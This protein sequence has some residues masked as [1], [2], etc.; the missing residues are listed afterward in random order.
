MREYKLRKNV[1]LCLL[2]CLSVSSRFTLSK[3]EHCKMCI[4]HHNL[5]PIHNVK[6]ALKQS[7]YNVMSLQHPMCQRWFDVLC[8]LGQT[9]D[10]APN[11]EKC[12]SL[13]LGYYHIQALQYNTMIFGLYVNRILPYSTWGYRVL[14]CLVLFLSSNITPNGFHGFAKHFL[15]HFTVRTFWWL[16]WYA[17]KVFIN[18]PTKTTIYSIAIAVSLW[19]TIIRISI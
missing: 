2:L 10:R 15:E 16:I 3:S 13:L 11:T 1:Y 19:I 17:D 8:P 5:V 6:S 9:I 14:S 18:F 12:E 4:F 7:S